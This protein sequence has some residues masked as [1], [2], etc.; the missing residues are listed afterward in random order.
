MCVF[1]CVLFIMYKCVFR[2]V[3]YVF[4]AELKEFLH[5]LD[6]RYEARLKKDCVQMAKKLRRFGEISCRGPPPEAPQ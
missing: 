2:Y 1:V 5:I 4:N 6:Q 3:A